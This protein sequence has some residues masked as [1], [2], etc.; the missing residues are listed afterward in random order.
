MLFPVARALIRMPQILIF[1]EVTNHLDY[2]SRMKMRDLIISL[3]GKT[4]VL[5][6]SHDPELIALCDKEINLEKIEKRR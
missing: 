3:R 1:D 2:T 6:V 5:M 4:T